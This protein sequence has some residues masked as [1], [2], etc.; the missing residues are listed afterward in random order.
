M[1]ALFAFLTVATLGGRAIAGDAQGSSE[2]LVGWSDD[3]TRYAVSGFT[4]AGPK[5][6]EFFLEVRE[7]GKAVYHWTQPDDPGSQSP[8][9]I[10]VETWDPLKKFKL[11]RLDAAARTRFAAK[12]VATS[13]TR[14]KDRFHCRPGGWSVKKKGGGAALRAEAAGK[15]RCVT[16]MGGYLNTAGTHALVKV[17]EAWQVT[18]GGDKR[19]EQHERFVLLPL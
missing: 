2:T 15:D 7:A 4:T 8:D 14:G 10:D 6:A 18:A 12:L 9:R 3:G 1:R 11:R 5:G 17:R 13:T 19:T 16:V